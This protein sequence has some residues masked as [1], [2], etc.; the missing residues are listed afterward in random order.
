MADRSVMDCRLYLKL[1]YLVLS[2]LLAISSLISCGQKSKSNSDSSVTTLEEPYC[3]DVTIVSGG[4]SL[5]GTAHYQY[6]K[7]VY[8]ITRAGLVKDS[9]NEPFSN[10]IRRAEVRVF[11]SNGSI[12]QCGETDDS[13]GISLA[14]PSP[15]SPEI[16]TVAVNSRGNNNYVKASVLDKVNTKSLYS[17]KAT[18]SVS[19]D[20]TAMTIPDLVASATDTLE[21]GAF[22]IYDRILQV[23][24]YLRN[25]TTD[26]QCT[27]CEGFTVA[28][29]VTVFWAKGFN[30]SAYFG[31][32]S[33][34]SFYDVSGSL[35][36]T[37]SLYI[38]GGSN[39]DVL[40]S[41]TDH[42]DESV[43]IH[44][45]GHFLENT[46]WRSDSPGGY[47][48]GNMIID[49]R[50]AFSEGFSNFL[51]SAVLGRSSYIDTIG[52]P[53]GATD[54]GVYLNLEEETGLSSSGVRD[55]IITKSQVGE[56]IYREISVSR[57]FY[58]YIDTSG[59]SGSELNEKTYDSSG[60]A[61]NASEISELPFAFLWLALTNVN[62]GLKAPD[63]HFVSMGHFNKS[64]YAA[65]DASSY[66]DISGE[67]AKLDSTR[68]GEFQAN[69]TLEYAP[70][71]TLSDTTCDRTM[72]PVVDRTASDGTSYH[73]IFLSSDFLRLD[74]SG[75]DLNLTLTYN[76]T[77]ATAPDL[78]LYVFR[79]VHS[80]TEASDL[81]GK[82]EATNSTAGNTE[83]ISVSNVPAGTYMILINADTNV[84]FSGGA[85]YRLTGTGGK[86]LCDAQ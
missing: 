66:A 85:T 5:T 39:G 4:V 67:K 48:N 58:D 12:V 79:E 6:Y 36:A 64:L 13:G 1:F 34:L 18:I 61:N 42:F 73:D 44:E 31:E 28:P 33:P 51:P 75:G 14:I 29:K 47:H 82:S 8:E 30:P 22:H 84:A 65:L 77:G 78:D 37:P 71:Q 15:L 27:L 62:F 35:D 80:I 81:I 10:P 57:A 26:S 83:S 2:S 21:G 56:G 9:N 41:D 20:T 32:T 74:H 24:D 38:L 76:A 46:Y 53:D 43:I 52:S 45:Y 25:H 68:L 86:N 23:N 54:I 7:G 50:L 55:K 3:S 19:P 16:Y 72:N 40:V 70:L 69:S 17:V 11:N 60:V 63:V 49:P 59:F